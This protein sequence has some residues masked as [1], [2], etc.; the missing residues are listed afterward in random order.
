MWSEWPSNRVVSSDN[1]LRF[2]IGPLLRLCEVVRPGTY[3]V[4]YARGIVPTNP[5]GSR[6]PCRRV[7]RAS[8]GSRKVG[9]PGGSL[10][11][12]FVP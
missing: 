2:L 1:E 9:F 3:I 5:T 12:P 6:D 11:G 7:I 8:V 10:H 4:A